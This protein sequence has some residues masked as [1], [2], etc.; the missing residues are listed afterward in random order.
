[1]EKREPTWPDKQVGARRQKVSYPQVNMDHITRSAT[2]ARVSAQ[3][4]ELSGH[5]LQCSGTDA[6]FFARDKNE[7]RLVVDRGVYRKRETSDSYVLRTGRTM[8][9]STISDSSVR[10]LSMNPS[11][12]CGDDDQLGTGADAPLPMSRRA[13]MKLDHFL[14]PSRTRSSEL[15]FLELLPEVSD[16]DCLSSPCN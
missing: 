3:I 14:S 6:R 4:D 13:P 8:S 10:S 11:F 7:R 12:L 2:Y 16:E 5:S 15:Q 1:M 9:S